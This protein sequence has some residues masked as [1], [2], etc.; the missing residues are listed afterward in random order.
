MHPKSGQEDVYDP[1]GRASTLRPRIH[2]G[3]LT[4]I[5]EAR[6]ASERQQMSLEVFVAG[7]TGVI[8]VRLVPLLVEAG[9]EVFGMSRS[10]AKAEAVRAAGATPVIADVF[11]AP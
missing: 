4:A 10:T 6:R 9:Y 7:A 8:G 1:E 2:L 5:D 3:A 11:D